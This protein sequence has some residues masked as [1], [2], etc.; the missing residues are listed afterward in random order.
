MCLFLPLDAPVVCWPQD[1]GIMVTGKRSS[2]FGTRTSFPG[3]ECFSR[4]F[5][6]DLGLVNL[7][8]KGYFSL[9]PLK[10]NYF[11]KEP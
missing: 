1:S 5:I 11:I 8:Y 9:P 7:S 4:V 6:L 10:K 3:G 2:S